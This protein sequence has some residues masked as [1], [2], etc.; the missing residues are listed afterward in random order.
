MGRNMF[1]DNR[2]VTDIR[3]RP[4]IWFSL[5]CDALGRQDFARAAAAKR[6]LKRLG[7]EV[8]FRRL[9]IATPLAE[10]RRDA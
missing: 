5:L 8:I 6:E 4:G 7:V 3:D 2:A 1:V 9:P 10:V